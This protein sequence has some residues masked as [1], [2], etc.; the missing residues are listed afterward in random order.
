MYSIH[1]NILPPPVAL[2]NDV[3]CFSIVQYTGNEGLTIRVSPK[4]VPGIVFQ[5]ANG[6]SALESIQTD[7]KISHAMPTLF[8][9]GAGIEP[10]IMTFRNSSYTCIQV[11]FK[12]HA[13][14]ALLGIN[15]TVL[16]GYFAELDEFSSRNFNE[17]LLN[18]SNIQQQ[19]A[20]LSDFLMTQLSR[21]RPRDVVIERSLRLI[22]CDIAGV[23]VK[24]LLD[25]LNLSERH[26]QRRFSQT[27]GISPQSYLRVK[28]FNEAIRLIKS[29]QY[30][31]LTDVA[32]A[33]NFYDQSHLIRDIKAFSGV[34][35]KKLSHKE[36]DFYD[37]QTGYS[38]L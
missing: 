9:Y 33:L 18:A 22:D 31:K 32:Y 4:A 20:L 5:H 2:K 8:L 36:D 37:V 7:A 6:H 29:G 26:F 24:S 1:F 27:V 3:E 16:S 14:N 34:T 12:P 35:P 28:R 13:L 21:E 17:R 10:S 19:I 30:E 11:I 15:A 23:S 25:Q 38:F